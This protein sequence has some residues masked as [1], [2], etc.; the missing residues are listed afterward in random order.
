MLI[1]F[2]LW[3][4]NFPRSGSHVSKYLTL[5]EDIRLNI[6]VVV[7]ASPH[8]G[9]RRLQ[10]LCDHIVNKPVLIPDLQF[11]KLRLVVPEGSTNI[12]KLNKTPFLLF[13]TL[14]M[15][16]SKKMI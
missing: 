14:L 13:P 7:L 10:H 3:F 2:S 12:T 6:S 8:K 5:C 1:A 15:T 11:V 4:H 9:S 16:Q